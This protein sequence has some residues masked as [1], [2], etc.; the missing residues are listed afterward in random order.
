LNC[1]LFTRA[2]A[3]C[4]RKIYGKQNSWTMEIEIT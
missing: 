3:I 1:P 4:D 2:L